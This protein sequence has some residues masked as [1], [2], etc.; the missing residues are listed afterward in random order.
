MRS[1]AAVL[2]LFSATSLF[3]ADYPPPSPHDFVV[4]D[5]RF[6]SGETLPEV[7]I[8]YVTL[9]TKGARNTVL[10]LHGTGGSSKQFLSANYAGVLF[11]PG[12][13]LD[14]SKYFI[15]IPDNVGHGGSSQPGPRP[16][17][18]FPHHDSHNM[19]D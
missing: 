4:K 1:L 17:G 2:L 5:Y 18:R 10:I 13:L 6:A 15:V 3:A 11:A 16:A 7:R 9:G 14:A 8:H 12:G 19:T